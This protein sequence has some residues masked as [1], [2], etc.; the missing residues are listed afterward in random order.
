[1]ISPLPTA[2]TG[3]AAT[4]TG[5]RLAVIGA[6]PTVQ[7]AAATLPVRVLH[8]QLPRAPA[9]P[10]VAGE[11]HTV[12]FRD[13]A[14]FGTFV[15]QVLAPL[16]PAAVV[17][18]TETGLEAAAVASARLGTPGPAPEVVR[19]TRDKLAMR[20]LLDRR[21]PRL[22]LDYAVGDDAAGV[23]RLFAR[24]RRVVAKPVDGSGSTDV[25]L[26]DRAGDLPAGRRTRDTLLEQYAG[27]R[28]Y[29]IEAMSQRGRHTVVG[30]AEKGVTTGFVE[31]SHLMPALSLTAGQRRQV[32]R[33]V[34]ELLDAVGIEDGPTHTEVK[35]DGGRVHVIETH[36]RLGGDGIADLVRLTTG[37]D[38]RRAALGWALGA[39][40]PRGV[41]DAAAAATVFFTAPPGRVV[42]VADPPALRTAAI[43]EW[44]LPVRPGDLVRPLGSSADRLG[45]AVLT[46]ASASEC[47]QGVA[48]LTARRTV[49]TEPL[50]H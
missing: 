50:G 30:I 9:A 48:E 40:L 4:I 8:I 26:L 18:L 34:S 15:E 33:A 23:E 44:D 5:G 38:W 24:H 21:A 43:A 14:A 6:N 47:A 10:D 17:S 46:A 20:R 29:S 28:E 32:V 42:A 2:R 7:R 22:N 25:A 39:G 11:F 31:V 12:D 45:H 3:N 19:A 1:V 36:N 35:L 16:A 27:G 37:L 13:P 41:P 49:S